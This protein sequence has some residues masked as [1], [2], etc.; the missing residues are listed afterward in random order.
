MSL[1]RTRRQVHFIER[2]EQ[3]DSKGAL[4]DMEGALEQVIGLATKLH[5]LLGSL[6]VDQNYLVSAPPSNGFS[7]VWRTVRWCGRHFVGRRGSPRKS[8]GPTSFGAASQTSPS[9][10]SERVRRGRAVGQ[11]CWWSRNDVQPLVALAGVGRALAKEGRGRR[12][13][14]PQRSG[15]V[16]AAHARCPVNKVHFCC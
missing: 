1:P 13:A 10:P 14:R 3:H 8:R 6:S 16:P 11:L 15:R 12:E 2:S 4:L 7:S 9:S 5:G